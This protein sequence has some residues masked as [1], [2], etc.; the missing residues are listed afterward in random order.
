V[1]LL[2]GARLWRYVPGLDVF[3]GDGVSQGGRFA[4]HPDLY[5]HA[6][7]VDPSDPDEIARFMLGYGSPGVDPVLAAGRPT[8]ERWRAEPPALMGLSAVDRKRRAEVRDAPLPDLG[9]FVIDTGASVRLGLE[10]IRWLVDTWRL[11]TEEQQPDR[12]DGA[13]ALRFGMVLDSCIA[14]AA[15]RV[16]FDRRVDDPDFAGYVA[17]RPPLLAVMAVQL[18]AHIARRTRWKTCR[19][20]DVLFE[21]PARSG[22]ADRHPRSDAQYHNDDCGRRARD[23]KSKRKRRAEGRG[24]RGSSPT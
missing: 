12:I 20:C 6:G 3:V 14:H 7:R 19:G 22:K 9:T 13:D 23:R 17:P 24:D 4:P 11:L 21:F 2:A 16:I 15:P 10:T 18:A 8:P 5:L 1:P